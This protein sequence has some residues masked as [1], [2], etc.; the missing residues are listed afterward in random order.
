MILIT[1]CLN[2]LIK[3]FKHCIIINFTT[4]LFT[5]NNTLI[6]LISIKFKYKNTDQNPNIKL[7][8]EIFCTRLFYHG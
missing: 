8:T 1:K 3:Q 2:I 5:L 4:I 7:M 6:Y